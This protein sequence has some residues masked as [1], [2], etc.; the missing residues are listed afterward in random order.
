MKIV[1]TSQYISG[2]GIIDKEPKTT[3]SK[4]EL[5]LST[6]LVSILTQWKKEQSKQR[7]K[8]GKEWQDNGKVFT[9]WNGV[10]MHPDTVS[11]YFSDLMAKYKDILPKVTLHSLRHSNICLQLY[12]WS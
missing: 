2:K 11:S 9:Q 3:S 4:R 5:I 1:R 7:L 12:R 10:T 6:G 8:V